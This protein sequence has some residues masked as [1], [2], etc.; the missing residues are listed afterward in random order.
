VKTYSEEKAKSHSIA[1][2]VYGILLIIYGVLSFL[3]E[4]LSETNT[5]TIQTFFDLFQHITYITGFYLYITPIDFLIGYGLLRRRAWAFYGVMAVMLSF[6][7]R[8]TGQIM[9][10][11]AKS[12]E[13]KPT[14]ISLLFAILILAYFSRTRIRTLVCGEFN[15]RLKSWPALLVSIVL[16]FGAL[17]VIMPLAMK[18]YTVIKHDQP[19]FTV[20]PE[21]VYLDDQRELG[22]SEGFKKIILLD[23]ET[24]IPNEF[25]I[26]R[27]SKPNE[28]YDWN[29]DL[30]NINKN[31]KGFIFLSHSNFIEWMKEK[32]DFNR[33]GLSDDFLIEK[34][35]HTNNWNPMLLIMREIVI[36]EHDGTL[37]QK[38][39]H[40]GGLKG[41]LRTW[42][43]NNSHYAEFHLYDNAGDGFIGGTFILDNDDYDESHAEAIISSINFISDEKSYNSEYYFKRGI[44][45]YSSGNFIDAQFEFANA[46]FLSPDNPEYSYML[47][48]SLSME[49]ALDYDGIKDLITTAL[50]NN[51]DHEAAKALLKEI[52]SRMILN[53]TE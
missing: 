3:F 1:V 24:T 6:P 34:F 40:T 37:V 16:I 15:F 23:I 8:I 35:F 33:M 9:W 20:K 7:F 38:E 5:D 53:D 36:P 29:V 14:V 18:A 2:S 46:Y 41:F 52:E 45:E 11:G 12:I 17:P 19:L 28:D 51:K 32:V 31:K 50:I 22:Q 47:A 25:V 10:W 43:R 27:V 39:V 13:D 49:G 21:I 4:Y 26:R 44:E 30:Q 48:K 42:R